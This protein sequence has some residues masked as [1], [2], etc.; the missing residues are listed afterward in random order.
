MCRHINDT[1]TAK[2]TVVTPYHFQSCYNSF[3]TISHSIHPLAV[4]YI[5]KD[6]NLKSLLSMF[7]CYVN[8]SGQETE[9]INV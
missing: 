3:V 1:K 4:F 8:C 2:K 9:F 5:N 7:V 6:V